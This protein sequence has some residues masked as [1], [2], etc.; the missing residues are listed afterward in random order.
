MAQRDPAA[1]ISMHLGVKKR[2]HNDTSKSTTSGDLASSF[3][4]CFLSQ[5][6]LEGM[7]DYDY[8]DM[9]HNAFA[10]SPQVMTLEDTILKVKRLQAEGNTLAEAGLFQAAIA[11][12]QHGLDIDPTNGTLY[13]LQAQAYLASNDVFRSIQA[14]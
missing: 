14:G 9:D 11:R 4:P 8:A 1:A 10:P 6:Q 7:S 13:E 3:A 2:K 5:S 12:W